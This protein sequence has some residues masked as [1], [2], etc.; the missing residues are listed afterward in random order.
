MDKL[1]L[2]G[3]KALK[4]NI[5]QLSEDAWTY[6]IGGEDKSDIRSY[7]QT[8]PWLFRGVTMRA[9]AVAAM[10]FEIT[11]GETIIDDSAEY[12]NKLGIID[13][14]Q[15][16][17]W[18]IESALT[19][20]GY[21]YLE[22]T[23]NLLGNKTMGVRYLL[24]TSITPEIDEQEGLTGFKRGLRQSEV[25]Y[26]PDEI[27]YFWEPDPFVEIGPPS[28]SSGKAALSASGVL[29][30]V[31]EFVAKFFQRGAIK[32]TI[33]GVPSG[34]PEG[35]REELKTWWQKVVTGINNAFTAKVINADAI[36][37]TTIGEGV[38][39]LQDTEL[40]D[41]KRE[42]IATALG[43]PQS[44]LFSNATNFA[45][46]QQDDLHF[47]SKTIVPECDF[48]EG[49][50]NE[51]IFDQMGYKFNFLPQTIDVF[52]QDE[53]ERAQA[54]GVYAQY[55]PVEVVIRMLG[56]ELDD[57]DWVAIEQEKQEKEE[58]AAEMAQN[59]QRSDEDEEE[60]EPDNLR[61][62]LG[63]WQRK[64]VK[65]LKRGESAAVEFDSEYIPETL[66][67]AIAG[68]LEGAKSVDDIDN[69]F[70]SVWVGYP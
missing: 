57:E 69:V 5:N 11:R 23:S 41:E 29:S 2:T 12:E 70:N 53:N 25:R 16:L 59:F 33:L 14:P 19:L 40:T 43:I 38:D 8:V 36:E 58:R 34:T 47:Y 56:L 45:T 24:P 10:P 66:N 42:D 62:H 60:E 39:G 27:C 63:K 9:Q 18:L 26:K 61:L 48:I 64:A 22:K 44:L 37:A 46:A 32:A 30:N 55:L 7:F 65:R 54:F 4:I 21:C 1:L 28:S 50:L 20:I 17:F 68:A 51:Q 49:V 67:A 15:R 6:L 35:A 52:Q 31:D 3:N 13:N